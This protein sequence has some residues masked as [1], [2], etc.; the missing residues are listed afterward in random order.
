MRKKLGQVLAC[1][2]LSAA[3]SLAVV[4]NFDD[5]GSPTGEA[6]LPPFDTPLAALGIS[7][8]GD[9]N[10]RFLAVMTGEAIPPLSGNYLHVN[11]LG[12]SPLTPST[13]TINFDRYGNESWWAVGNSVFMDL[14]DTE[15]S[16]LVQVFGPGG[17]QLGSDLFF[18]GLAET[19][20]VGGILGL[21]ALDRIHFIRILDAGGDGYLL[22]NLT[23][24]LESVVPEPATYALIA[25]GLLLGGILRRRG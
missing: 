4:V 19:V 17:A 25:S 5:I 2:L 23:F 1:L 10:T 6:G 24:E 16:I 22:D 11:S 20:D 9:A 7:I 13:V 12:D 18:S 3:P 15:N 8:N 14:Y 21:T